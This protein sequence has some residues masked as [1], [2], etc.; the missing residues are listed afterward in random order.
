VAWVFVILKIENDDISIFLALLLFFCTDGDSIRVP[1]TNDAPVV[2]G[3]DDE[4]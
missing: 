2:A 1:I 3:I 4:L